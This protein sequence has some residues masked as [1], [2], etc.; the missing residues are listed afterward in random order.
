M[1]SGNK[2]LAKFPLLFKILYH[3]GVTIL[4]QNNNFGITWHSNELQNYPGTNSCQG[5][6]RSCQMEW[7]LMFPRS[8]QVF[9]KILQDLIQILVKIRSYKIFPRTYKEFS[10]ILSRSSR[11]IYLKSWQDLNHITGS[12]SYSC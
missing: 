5:I 4:A 6:I 8:W 12:Y 2:F 7:F 1:V 10:K 3:H 9:N 11:D